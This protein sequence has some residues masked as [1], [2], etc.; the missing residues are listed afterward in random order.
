MYVPDNTIY[1]GPKRTFDLF[2]RSSE[3]SLSR[4]NSYSPKPHEKIENKPE[5][6]SDPKKGLVQK[7]IHESNFHISKP[8]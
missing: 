4:E 1:N 6:F 3:E 5:I 7:L 8:E 2:L